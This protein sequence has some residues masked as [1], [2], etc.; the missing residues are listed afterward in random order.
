MSSIK[1]PPL[2][3]SIVEATISRWL[4]NEGDRVAAGSKA[5]QQLLQ[6]V[7]GEGRACRAGARGAARGAARAEMRA[8]ARAVANVGATVAAATAVEEKEEVVVAT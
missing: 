3:E 7:A 4:K 6:L 5:A 1:V 8:A 2:G